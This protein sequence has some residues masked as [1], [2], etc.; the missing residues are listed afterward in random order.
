MWEG[1]SLQKRA[2]SAN[3]SAGV[4]GAHSTEDP[5]E[6]AM[7]RE[8]AYREETCPQTAVG[9][10]KASAAAK[11]VTGRQEAAFLAKETCRPD[12][13]YPQHYTQSRPAPGRALPGG[14]P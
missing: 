14:A 3:R 9:R 6:S 12:R 10:N 13:Q 1:D 4:S 11:C 7:R 8:G 2:H 5:A